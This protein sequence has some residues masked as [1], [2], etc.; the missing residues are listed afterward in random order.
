MECSIS[1]EG[2]GMQ[3]AKAGYDVH[4]IDYEGHGKSSGLQGYI[5]TFDDLVTDCS[6]YFI[7]VCGK[8]YIHIYIY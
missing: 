5:S 7:S 3:L 8:R 2:T 6:D 4:G 1:M